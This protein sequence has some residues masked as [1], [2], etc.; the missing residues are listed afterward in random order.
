MASIPKYMD[1]VDWAV[2][3]I[4]S[5]VFKPKDKFLSE[6]ALGEKF[7]CSRQTVRRALEVLEQQ[8]HI[9]RIQGSG[10]YISPG[11]HPIRFKTAEKRGIS[12]TVGL[13]STFMDNYIFPSI[14]RGIEGV[15]S[16]NGIALQ[17]AS[18]NNLVSGETR[19]LQMMLERHL[20][21]LIVEPTRSALPCANLDLYHTIR[22]RGIPLLFI[23]SFYPELSIPYVTLDD[24][25]AGYAATKYL[26]GRGHRDIAGI[27]P[28]SNR[29]GHLRYLGYVKALA[30]QGIAIQDHFVFWHSKEDMHQI[31]HSE[32]LLEGLSACT[33]VLCYND[34]TALTLIDFLRQ[35]G[36]NVPN[37]LSV[38]GIDNSELAKISSL[39]SVVHP[40]E[41][42]GEAAANLLVS[43]INGAEGK[44]ILFPPQ[45]VMRTSVKDA[46]T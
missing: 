15:F 12:R 33:A 25:K 35:N 37:D 26:I 21:G 13:I 43:M 32:K 46:T 44:N 31:L 28:H 42:L 40:A 36:R 20:D 39:T 29:Q 5:D 6:A 30:E 19:S 4:A 38:V 41:Q 14:I 11:F 16:S 22:Q 10:T 23:D 3:Q 45:L 9:I 17:L 7:R 27:F 1:I 24:V 8:G 2:D 18:T 34:F